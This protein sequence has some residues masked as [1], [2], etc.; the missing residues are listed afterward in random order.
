[1]ALVRQSVSTNI[2]GYVGG[3]A[4]LTGTFSGSWTY[5]YGNGGQAI[6]GSG[7]NYAVVDSG[8]KTHKVQAKITVG[9]GISIFCSGSSAT[10]T[11][12]V[13]LDFKTID[14][15]NYIVLRFSGSNFSTNS[16]NPMSHFAEIPVPSQIVWGAI[17]EFEI[18]VGIYGWRASFKNS[19]SV[20]TPLLELPMSSPGSF[21]GS[22]PATFLRGDSNTWVGV[23]STVSGNN[24]QYVYSY[25]VGEVGNALGGAV[26]MFS[27][28]FSRSNAESPYNPANASTPTGTYVA[29]GGSIS[30]STFYINSGRLVLNTTDYN[31]ATLIN[32]TSF[33]ANHPSASEYPVSMVKFVYYAGVFAFS[34]DANNNIYFN[35][36]ISGTPKAV[37]VETA[38]VDSK[39]ST[40]TPTF[41]TSSSQTSIASGSTVWIVLVPTLTSTTYPIASASTITVAVYVQ[42]TKPTYNSTPYVSYGAPVFPF[43][44]LGFFTQPGFAA[45]QLSSLAYSSESLITYGNG[46][47]AAPVSWAGYTPISHTNALNSSPEVASTELVGGVYLGTDYVYQATETT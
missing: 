17:H 30:S 39:T 2:P 33:P 7:T 32:C 40:R 11:N 38:T 5:S 31:N 19:S 28:T 45:G 10:A 34:F 4:S 15:N 14:S 35:S 26:T 6:S 37:T 46:T 25:I 3:A 16:S 23:K 43:Q 47:S 13:F 24:V 8:F 42:T 1:M 27:D 44:T 22:I 20:W 36:N 18:S 12:A 21:P 41:P 9:D 29:P